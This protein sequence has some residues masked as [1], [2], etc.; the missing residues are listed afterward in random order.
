MTSA[1]NPS[2]LIE[3]IPIFAPV[4]LAAGANL[5]STT[6]VDTRGFEYLLV[7]LYMGVGDTVPLLTAKEVAT[8]SAGT[9]VAITGKTLTLA[10]DDDG[11]SISM[12]IRCHGIERY[13]E[14]NLTGTGVSSS[15]VAIM[16]Y[17]IRNAR[18]ED[19]QALGTE[20]VS[21]GLS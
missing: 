10:A 11:K 5:S 20:T 8:A 6:R 21:L 17:G 15:L 4:A 2:D 16:C 12:E 19:I 14:F 13:V 7:T 3:E 1:F 18:S 9:P